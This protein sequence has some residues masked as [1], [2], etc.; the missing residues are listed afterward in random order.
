[1]RTGQERSEIANGSYENNGRA[2]LA[3]IPAPRVAIRQALIAADDPAERVWK[4]QVPAWII[5][6]GIHLTLMALFLIYA[7]FV[8]TS[9]PASPLESQ[10]VETKVVDDAGVKQNFENTD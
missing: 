9:M 6:G 7:Y 4:R 2:P 3:S 1:M 8:P 5:S 10:L